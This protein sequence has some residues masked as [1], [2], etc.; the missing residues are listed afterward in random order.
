MAKLKNDFAAAWIS[1][2]LFYHLGLRSDG[3]GA[4]LPQ[5]D[6]SLH[7]ILMERPFLAHS[8]PLPRPL[9]ARSKRS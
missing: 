1:S 2:G 3:P 5:T 9:N 6:F 4:D 8:G 7:C